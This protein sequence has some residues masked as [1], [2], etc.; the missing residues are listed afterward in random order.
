MNE[1]LAQLVGQKTLD[2]R[3]E[4]GDLHGINSFLNKS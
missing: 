1:Q 2:L 3:M 4:V